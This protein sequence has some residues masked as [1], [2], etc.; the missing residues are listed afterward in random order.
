MDWAAVLDTCLAM[1][2]PGVGVKVKVEVA[3][4]VGVKVDVG[5]KVI[6]GV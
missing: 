1:E 2:T 4:Q 5:V 6:V 3:V